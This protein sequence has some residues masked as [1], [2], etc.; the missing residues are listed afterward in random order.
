MDPALANLGWSEDQWNRICNVVAEEAQRARVC[1]QALPVVGEHDPTVLAVPE[2]RVTTAAE[3]FPFLPAA[4]RLTV[5]SDPTLFLTTISVNVAIR[6]QEL[7][8]P[9]L[10]AALTMFR[11]AA[12]YIARIEDTLFFNGRAAGAAPPGVGAGIPPVYTVTGNG[13]P[14]GILQPPLPGKVVPPYPP[15]PSPP[16]N[17]N[18]VFN[19]IVAAINR[20]EGGGATGPFACIL[21]N[22]LFE[23]ICTPVPGSLVLPRDRVLPFLQGPLLRSGQIPGTEGCVIALGGSP[24]EIVVGSDISV[25]YLQTTAEPRYMFRVSERVAL[26]IKEP[27]SIALL[28]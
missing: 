13:T 2:Y 15:V 18:D 5:N 1:A 23:Y 19:Q 11:R 24:V 3:P 21:S 27:E 10:R 20:L 4:Q 14:D 17:G 26:R 28:G 8:D 25:R 7:S 16:G 12:N 22:T 6:T 9:E